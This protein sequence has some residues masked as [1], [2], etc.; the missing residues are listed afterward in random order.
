M[1]K[2]FYIVMKCELDFFE[3]WIPKLCSIH[4]EKYIIVHCQST[5]PQNV[6][7]FRL[8]FTFLY[9]SSPKMVSKMS[10]YII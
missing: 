4:C 6:S 3:E 9:K 1:Q 5:Y 2:L 10:Y 8:V 7:I